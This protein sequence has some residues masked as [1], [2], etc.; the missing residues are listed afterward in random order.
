MVGTDDALCLDRRIV[1]RGDTA[2]VCGA[3]IEVLNQP[4]TL[5]VYNEESQTSEVFL[6]V[7]NSI[8]VRSHPHFRN[9]AT[10]PNPK[11]ML[12]NRTIV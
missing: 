7:I 11:L 12:H 10:F 3:Q 2:G 8:E 6:L 1:G 9:R 4:F 5:C